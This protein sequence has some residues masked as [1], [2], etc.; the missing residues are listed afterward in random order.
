MDKSRKTDAYWPRISLPL[1][2]PP[3]SVHVICIHLNQAME[4]SGEFRPL[5]SDD[6]LERA[7]RFRIDEPRLRFTVCRGV[8]RLLLASCCGV[9]ANDIAFQ[10]GTHGKPELSRIG[11]HP[12]TPQ[13]EFNVSHSHDLGLIAIAAGTPVGIDIEECNPKVKAIKLAER[14]FAP[15]E[16]EELCNLPIDQQLAGFYRGWTCKEA[17]IKA[18]GRGMSL[19]LSSFRVAIDPLQPASLKQVADQPNEPSRWTTLALD[20]APNYA[21]TVM[22]AKPNCRFELWNWPTDGC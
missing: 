2:L 20:V 14:F 21:A 7:T 10:Y 11:L 4:R 13:I 3:D 19:S 16:S 9:A 17:Y 15:S 12:D 1:E 22:A 18:T 5:L 8:L 6:E